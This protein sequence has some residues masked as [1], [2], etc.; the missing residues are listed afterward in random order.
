MAI[1]T[2]E[3]IVH[4]IGDEQR[5]ASGF[6]KRDLVVTPVGEGEMSKYPEYVTFSFKKDKCALLT[7]LTRGAKVRVSFYIGGRKWEK[8]GKVRYFNELTGN[9]VEILEGAPNV[10]VPEPAT[11]PDDIG[12]DIGDDSDLP[13]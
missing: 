2:Y 3:G 9:K 13:F 4:E 12:G 6:T 8:D 10:N 11:P 5:F 1:S 7:G